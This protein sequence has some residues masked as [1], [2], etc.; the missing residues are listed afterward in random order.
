MIPWKDSK[1]SNTLHSPCG[2]YWEAS[3]H[4]ISQTVTGP[5]PSWPLSSLWLGQSQDW[6]VL[7]DKPWNSRLELVCLLSGGM[8]ISSDIHICSMHIA[9]PSSIFYPLYP[10][11][12]WSKIITWFFIEYHCY[13]DDNTRSIL[14]QTLMLL[15]RSH[16]HVVASQ[17]GWQLITCN[18]IPWFNSGQAA[19]ILCL[20][21]KPVTVM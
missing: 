11:S 16:K 6:A 12:P 13:A 20:C 4:Y 1:Q 14:P 17:H 19:I 9:G 7:P 18:E 2:C 3:R 8:V 21:C 15:C 5:D 10:H